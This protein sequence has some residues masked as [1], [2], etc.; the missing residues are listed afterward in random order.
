MYILVFLITIGMYSLFILSKYSETS[1][2]WTSLEP[3]FV[4]R[5]RQIF[6]LYRV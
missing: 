1:L 3:A 5:S 2:S 4:F 6:C